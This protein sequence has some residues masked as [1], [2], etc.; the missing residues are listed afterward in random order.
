M[1]EKIMVKRKC[2]GLTKTSKEIQ[3][4]ILDFILVLMIA[5][6]PEMNV[7]FLRIVSFLAIAE[8]SR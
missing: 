7:F 2:F 6:N 8:L 4:F 3:S 5:V 1:K